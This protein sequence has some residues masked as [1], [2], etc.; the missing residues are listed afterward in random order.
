MPTKED[1]RYFQSMPLE[2]KVG[3]TRTRIREW[4]N[5]YGESGT[6]VSFSGG[7]D[8]TVLLHLVRE[9]YPDISAMFVNTGLE[10]PEIQSFV[11]SFKNIMIVR[12]E[13]RFDQVIKQ[14]GYPMITK[15]ISHKIYDARMGRKWSVKYLKGQAKKSDGSPSQFNI[16][17]YHPLTEVDFCISHKCCDVMKKGP[18]HKYEKQTSRVAITAV[19]ASES[20]M[21]EAQW[22]RSGCNAFDNKKPISNPMSFWTEN[23]VLQYI[24]QND[25][26]IASVYGQVI[27]C[28]NLYQL[29]MLESQDECKYRTTGCDRTGCIF[30][31]FGAHLHNDQRFVRLKQTH[32]KQYN[33]CINGG[34]YDIDGFWKPNQ[35]G[36]GLG[37]VIDKLNELYSKN[38]KAFI[39]Y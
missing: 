27:N 7:K 32:P 26:Q 10:F 39:E 33:Y 20:R 6:Y 25:I 31:G 22:I 23:D 16:P 18:A 8:S 37:H 1:L 15:D 30:C 3:M 2:I 14:Y 4:V 35:K 34:E 11:K 24:K 28:D 38:G 19:M 13:M 5:Y 12:P 36:L 21:R 29:S 9:L 17:K